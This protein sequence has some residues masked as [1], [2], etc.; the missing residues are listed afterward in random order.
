MGDVSETRL[1]WQHVTGTGSEERVTQSQCS[2]LR[3]P[4]Q[5]VDHLAYQYREKPLVMARIIAKVKVEADREQN[6]TWAH[7]HYWVKTAQSAQ[8]KT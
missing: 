5:V 6:V 8:H 4:K 3:D 2:E 1:A 7:L